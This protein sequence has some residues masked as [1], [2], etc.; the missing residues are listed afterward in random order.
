MQKPVSPSGM[1]PRP[2]LGLP[3]SRPPRM[4][5]LPVTSRWRESW[6]AKGGLYIMP[7]TL[8]QCLCIHAHTLSHYSCTGKSG[9]RRR[10]QDAEKMKKGALALESN[11]LAVI[12]GLSALPFVQSCAGRALIRTTGDNER[13]IPHAACFAC[14]CAQTWPPPPSRRRFCV[15]HCVRAHADSRLQSLH[16]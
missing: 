2:P 10:I 5:S 9:G 15:L 4:K 11:R 3:P 7:F 14:S 13:A 16:Q 12:L 6:S 1:Y 8:C